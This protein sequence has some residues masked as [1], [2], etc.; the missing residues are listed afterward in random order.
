[1]KSSL[2][3]GAAIAAVLLCLAGCAAPQ[4]PPENEPSIPP[5]APPAPTSTPFP[6]RPAN[7]RLDGIDP[8]GLVTPTQLKQ[9]D[10]RQVGGRTTPIPGVVECGWGGNGFRLNT[11]IGQLIL[12]H[13][14]TPTINSVAPV[15]TVQIDGF[16]ALQGS[17][18]IDDGK[19]DCDQ[20]F[21]IADGQSLLIG[22]SDDDLEKNGANGHDAACRIA[23]KFS[24]MA[25]NNLRTMTHNG[26]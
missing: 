1:M 12:N 17:S 16:T 19:A 10:A 8:C 9:L 21:D 13:G 20:L 11:W 2:L 4:P 6:P 26:G 22:Y 14:I 18:P 5:L 24:T 7:L 23:S 3:S 15:Q 25:I